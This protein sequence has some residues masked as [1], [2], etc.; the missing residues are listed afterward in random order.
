MLGSPNSYPPTSIFIR[1]LPC[2]TTKNLVAA[3]IA[4]YGTTFSSLLKLA[5]KV[6][7]WAHSPAFFPGLFL[8]HQIN[9][10]VN[11]PDLIIVNDLLLGG[12]GPI[13][14]YYYLLIK[15]L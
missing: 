13:L 9:E 6:A 14:Y 2:Q 10:K 7:Q 5:S 11:L 15:V 8:E 3:L 1:S 12:G 4:T